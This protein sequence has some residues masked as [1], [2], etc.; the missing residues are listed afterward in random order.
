MASAVNHDQNF[1]NLILDYPRAALEFF[2]AAEAP[3]PQDA[4]R[5]VPVRQEQLQERLGGRWRGLDVPL[6]VHWEHGGRDAI[7]FALE[8]ESEGR[9]FSLHRLA[10][11]CLDLAELLGT[12]RVVP[13][14]IFLRA[15]TVPESLVL[16]TERRNYLSFGYLSC[17]LSELSA[18]AWLDSDNPVARVNLPNMRSPAARR[19]EVY[20]RAVRGLLTL[21]PDAARRA[22]YLE[23]IDIYAGLTENE[24]ER[25]RRQHPEDGG[26]MAGVI[27][28][29]RD[30]GIQQGV[31]RGIRQGVQQGIQQGVRQGRIAG[32]RAILERQLLRRFGTLPPAVLERLDT[33]SADDLDAWAE[34][35]LDAPT[36]EDV[37]GAAS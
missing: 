6:L 5:V 24:F 15:G 23:F 10:H 8:E 16:G 3:A 18:D 21:E 34:G 35:V 33:A 17:K 27:Q 32:R 4:V 36:L 19:V 30:E 14:S 25:Y 13:V 29:A 2:A 11:Y 31:Q 20:A 9:H 26:T 37:F 28:R 1:K 12:D 7:V 22:K